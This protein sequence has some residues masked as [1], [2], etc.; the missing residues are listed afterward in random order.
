LN[1]S[2]VLLGGSW[3]APVPDLLIGALGRLRR[4]NLSIISNNFGTD[5]TDF[6]LLFKHRLVSPFGAQPEPDRTD[7][8]AIPAGRGGNGPHQRRLDGLRSGARRIDIWSDYVRLATLAP[9]AERAA[10]QKLM[11]LA[12]QPKSA[13]A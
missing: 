10:F 12:L 1:S 8:P 13:T 5:E 9:G 2:F 4:R 7:R 6:V 3:E 11:E